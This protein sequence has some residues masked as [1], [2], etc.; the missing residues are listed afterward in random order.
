MELAEFKKAHQAH[1]RACCRLEKKIRRPKGVPEML[2][3]MAAMVREGERWDKNRP[4]VQARPAQ[5]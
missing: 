3:A 2:E 4:A 1:L 5:T